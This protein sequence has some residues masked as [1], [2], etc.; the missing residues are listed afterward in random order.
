MNQYYYLSPCVF[1]HRNVCR[2][3][4]QLW[5]ESLYEY[6][7]VDSSQEMGQLAAALRRGETRPTRASTD[8]QHDYARMG[9]ADFL[10][11]F[12]MRWGEARVGDE[13]SGIVQQGENQRRVFQAVSVRIK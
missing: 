9:H 6:Q 11:V 13:L 4:H 12:P 1:I 8:R 2:A 3:A 5:A 7:C 10:F